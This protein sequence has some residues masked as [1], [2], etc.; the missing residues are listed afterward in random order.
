M[1][2]SGKEGT[3]HG[4]PGMSITGAQTTAL[5]LLAFLRRPFGMEDLCTMPGSMRLQPKYVCVEEDY[6]AS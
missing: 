4:H 5:G 1:S 3:M 2:L 6:L